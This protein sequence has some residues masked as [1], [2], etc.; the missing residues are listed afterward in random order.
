MIGRSFLLFSKGLVTITVPQEQPVAI[1]SSPTITCTRQE[2]L[3]SVKWVLTDTQNKSTPITNGKQAT[4]NRTN[5]TDTVQLV[6]ISG[7]W[8]GNVR[9]Y[10]LVFK[11]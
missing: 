3:G 2:D 6:N 7:S 11:S 10:D 9:S 1:G 4:L 8:K 5:F